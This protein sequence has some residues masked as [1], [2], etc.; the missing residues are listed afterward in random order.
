MKRIKRK[1]VNTKK[2]AALR[3][4]L[5]VNAWRGRISKVIVIAVIFPLPNSNASEF[6]NFN[7]AG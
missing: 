4:S 7:F 2:E 5:Q 3:K 6:A 1:R